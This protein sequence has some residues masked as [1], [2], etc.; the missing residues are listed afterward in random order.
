MDRS[1]FQDSHLH[2]SNTTR[3]DEIRIHPE[4]RQIYL[5][6]VSEKDFQKISHYAKSNKR[7]FP[8]FGLHPWKVFSKREENTVVIKSIKQIIT[9]N[10]CGIGECGLD[11][12]NKYKKTKE[13][14]IYLFRECLKI[15]RDL[16]L[17]VSIHCV[18][19]WKEVF[20]ILK[21]ITPPVF[22]IHSFYASKEI[23]KIIA[24]LGG[25]FSL[26]QRSFQ[27]PKKSYSVIKALP[28]DKIL[29]ETDFFVG[30]EKE[31]LENH[32][33]QL[34]SN[35]RLVSKIFSLDIETLKKRIFTNGEIFKN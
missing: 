13:E 14:Q 18:K 11:F 32:F 26:S 20:D 4:I 33:N 19:A 16:D 12:S 9:Q 3:S 5:N 27:N 35:Y 21:K 7:I 25:Y 10:N 8:F 30:E 2:I 17:P 31:F 1:F 28:L 6:S 24:E 23:A 34:V 22:I 29:I 15:S